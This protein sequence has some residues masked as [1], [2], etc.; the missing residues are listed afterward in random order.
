MGFLF[1]E[2]FQ[3]IEDLTEAKVAILNIKQNYPGLKKY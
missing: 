3:T 2:Y 1:I